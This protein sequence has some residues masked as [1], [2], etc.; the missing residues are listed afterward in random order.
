MPSKRIKKHLRG[1]LKHCLTSLPSRIG[2]NSESV[3]LEDFT[4]KS[5]VRD[6]SFH[7]KSMHKLGISWTYGHKSVPKLTRDHRAYIASKFKK[8]KNKVLTMGPVEQVVQ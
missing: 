2:K 1:L 8:I 7:V 5:A 4:S 3:A 6:I